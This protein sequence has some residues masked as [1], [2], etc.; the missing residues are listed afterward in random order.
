MASIADAARAQGHHLIPRV[1]HP[2]GS[3]LG[4]ALASGQSGAD[5]LRHGP[6]R[7]H[8]LG[9]RV[10]LADASS[11]KS[12]GRLVKNVTGYD[13]HRLYCGSHGTLCVILEAS[14]RLAAA[15]ESEVVVTTTSPDRATALAAASTMLRLDLQPLA[16]R[17]ENVLE[18]GTW[19]AHG[20][21]GGRPAF[22]GWARRR[23][24]ESLP[25]ARTEVEPVER[26]LDLD[27]AG[28][29]WPRVRAAGLPSRLAAAVV[30]IDESSPAIL[31]PG[32]ASA[33]LIDASDEVARMLS[34]RGLEVTVRGRAPAAEPRPGDAI[35]RRL[36]LAFD[37]H[38]V[39]AT[40]SS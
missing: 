37:P 2:D 22:V 10:L 8:V 1:P 33:E 17:V 40:G 39:F 25:G 36:R 14:M 31:D 15:P 24:L 20:I 30:H 3:T 21:L 16:V 28:G 19:R 4:G 26:I 7:H 34:Q 23:A 27:L 5:R 13:M 32:I 38:G 6:A 29:S 18:A 12:G 11:A 9:M 35:E